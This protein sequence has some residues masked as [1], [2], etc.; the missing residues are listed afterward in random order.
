MGRL[1]TQKRKQDDAEKRSC[2]DLG[3][4]GRIGGAVARAF[5]KEGVKVFLTW[6]HGAAFEAVAK[7]SCRWGAAEAAEVNALD[8][9]SIDK[10]LQS[11]IDMAGR[12]DILGKRLFLLACH[13][14]GILL[15]CSERFFRALLL[16][17]SYE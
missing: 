3:A 5:A 6:F 1:G 14:E 10:H 16:P 12:L 7:D 4:G 8:E 15:R 9:Q 13:V 17:D 11:V 2:S